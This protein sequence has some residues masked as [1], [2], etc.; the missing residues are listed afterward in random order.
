MRKPITVA[1]GVCLAAIASLSVSLRAQAPQQPAQSTPPA[2]QQPPGQFQPPPA[3]EQTLKYLAELREQIRGKEAQP[4]GDVFKNIQ[5]MKEV[6][7]GR[8]LA[9][10]RI[11]YAASLGVECTH[12]H[13][14]GEWEKDDKEPKNIARKMSAF[15]R[16]TNERLAAIRQGAIVNCTTCHRGQTKPALNLP[17]R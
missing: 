10:M 9:I 14:A 11:G 12:C 5:T 6:P 3:S 8:L 4:A 17:P 15:A 16:E 7:A 2:A 1:C 13:V